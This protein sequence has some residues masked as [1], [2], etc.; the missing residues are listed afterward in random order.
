MRREAPLGV[1]LHRLSCGSTPIES[2]R[3]I[4]VCLDVKPEV[5][6]TWTIQWHSKRSEVMWNT[7]TLDRWLTDPEKFIPGQK[8]GYQVPDAV[9]RADIVAYLQRESAKR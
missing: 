1:T 8:M 3:C 5:S 4:A 2:A 6:R 9:D 7:Q